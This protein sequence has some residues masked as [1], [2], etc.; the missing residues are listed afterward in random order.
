MVSVRQPPLKV[1]HVATVA[2][3][4][5]Y[6]LANQLQA[7]QRAGYEVVGISAPGS[8]AEVLTAGGIR[9]IAVPLSRAVASPHRD[10]QALFQMYRVMRRERFTIVHTHT[11]KAGIL[12]RLAARIAGVPVVVNTVHGFYIH[13]GMSRPSRASVIGL[14]RLAARASDLTLCQN[15]EDVELAIEARICDPQRVRYLG[16]GIDLCL[17]DR[18]SVTAAQIASVRRAIGIPASHR[19]VGFVGRLAA[20]RKGFVD[21]LQAGAELAKRVPSARFL[22]VG[23]PDRDRRDAVG[24]EAAQTAGILDRCH[25]VGQRDNRELPALYALMDVVVLPSLFEGLPRVLMEA[26]AMG[27]PA[28]A[29]NVKGNREAIR[30]GE[31][32]ALVEYGA[33][34]QLTDAIGAL[35]LD[36]DRARA[37]SRRAERFARERFDERQ[38]FARVLS[39]YERLLARKRIHV[40]TQAALAG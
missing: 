4:L 18:A 20:R 1:A 16:N 24:P 38:V 29:S 28:V 22:I 33:V 26:A 35:L 36:A 40:R 6:L 14:E 9:H 15:R 11:P 31:T 12:G 21:F 17:F 32:G 23:E 25:F 7:I 5:R 39:E 8:D 37:M 19:V 30:D 34:S 13:D 3:S 10:L 27:V 2:L